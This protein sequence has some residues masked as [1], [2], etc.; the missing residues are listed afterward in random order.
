ML[1]VKAALKS[2]ALGSR[3]KAKYCQVLASVLAL[4]IIISVIFC[5]LKKKIH[6]I[7]GSKYEKDFKSSFS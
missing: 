2:A 3:F 1:C 4:V 5:R 6:I 7:L